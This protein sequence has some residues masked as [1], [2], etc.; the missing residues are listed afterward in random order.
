MINPRLI[1]IAGGSGSGKSTA[2][3]GLLDRHPNHTVV[4]NFDDYHKPSE[5]VPI[6]HNL[7]NW[8]DPAAI[9]FD[10]LNKDLSALLSGKSFTIETKNER[11][12]P[13]YASVSKTPGD[14]D[15][16]NRGIGRMKVTREPKEVIIL[17]GYLALFDPRVNN[18]A[19]TKIFLDLNHEERMLRRTKF[20]NSIYEEKI[21]KPMHA[22][23]VEPTKEHADYVL[24]VS[25]MSKEEVINSVESI[26]GFPSYA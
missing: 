7:T 23:Y 22:K 21:L 20:L 3:F 8:D 4:I 13:D 26:I 11:D 12:N 1:I 5:E 9:N 24:D 19:S 18:L 16:S 10:A 14:V 25:N 6:L 15:T 17:E 2:S